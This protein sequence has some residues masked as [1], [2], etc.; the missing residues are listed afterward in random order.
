MRDPFSYAR[1]RSLVCVSLKKSPKEVI[2]RN[3]KP[4]ETHP[5]CELAQPCPALP[6][7][8]RLCAAG[9]CDLKYTLPAPR[10]K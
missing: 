6:G 4:N 10:F 2:S 3:L 1:K 7:L 9:A 8:A 5:I